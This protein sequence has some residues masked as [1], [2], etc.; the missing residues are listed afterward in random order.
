MVLFGLFVNQNTTF[1]KQKDPLDLIKKVSYMHAQ[2]CGNHNN[3]YNSTI[4]KVTFK[5]GK[6][7]NNSICDEIN[8]TF[9]C[10]DPGDKCTTTSHA[11]SGSI[12]VTS[13]SCPSGTSSK[14]WDCYK[15]YIPVDGSYQDAEGIIKRLKEFDLTLISVDTSGRE[16]SSVTGLGRQKRTVF[17]GQTASITRGYTNTGYTFVGFS[18]GTPGNTISRT[19]YDDTVIYAYY[20]GESGSSSTDINVKNDTVPKYGNYAK[21]TYAKPG[22]IRKSDWT[23]DKVTYSASYSPG[24]QSGT[25][26]YP[27]NVEIN[28]GWACGGNNTVLSMNALFNACRGSS[29]N[30]WNNAFSVTKNN[31]FKSDTVPSSPIDY[32]GFGIGDTTTISGKEN[33]HIVIP[34]EAGRDLTENAVTNRVW[35]TRDTPRSYT[36]GLAP[37]GVSSGKVSTAPLDSNASTLVPYNFINDPKKP[38]KKNPGDIPNDNPNDDDGKDDDINEDDK[39]KIV[40][41]G[42]KDTFSFNIAVNPR[43]NQETDGEYATIVEKAK[44]RLG[45]CIGD[46]CKSSNPEY[47]YSEIKEGDLNEKHKLEG[48]PSISKELDINIP[49]IKAG[50]KICVVSEVFP[51][52]SGSYLNW[53]DTNYDGTWARSPRSCYTVAKRPSIQTW[54]GNV[55]T[56][57]KIETSTAE[58]IKKNLMGYASTHDAVAEPNQGIVAFGSWNELGVVANNGIIGFGSGASM[59]YAGN[60]GIQNGVFSPW[61]MYK[62]ESNGKTASY[63][64]KGNLPI[65]NG[66]APGGSEEKSYCNRVPLTIPNA[67]CKEG[68][69]GVSGSSMQSLSKASDDKQ[70]IVDILGGNATTVD[71]GTTINQERI[72]LVNGSETKLFQSEGDIIIDSDLIYFDSGSE[73]KS[74]KDMPKLVIYA[75]NIKINCNV[76]R[77]D[78]LLI[79]KRAVLT[80][81]NLGNDVDL[82]NTEKVNEAIE[83]TKNNEENSTQL[84]VNG[85][86]IANRLI[87]NRTYGAATGPNSIISAEIINFDPTLYKFNVSTSDDKDVAGRLDVASMHELP[88]RL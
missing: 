20:R 38:T 54:G 87:A 36:I 28:G 58:K 43:Y 48:E 4:F 1:A 81:N 47:K 77:I 19:M 53:N 72:G 8:G 68:G 22:D 52:T 70:S 83:R 39:G 26:F 51:K 61:P 73:Y 50:S 64:G 17:Y 32:T 85:A 29:Y 56:Q 30:N 42:E 14:K 79:A 10:V 21:T 55:Y 76:E 2:G 18:D 71:N 60:D 33:S 69:I 46:Q 15:V 40:Y 63:R 12:K 49:D 6:G 44:W 59:G 82:S 16:L 80:C 45:L 65:I 35:G 75:D 25:R 27:Q 11:H 66:R 84:F 57:G 86:I 37:S 9:H 31:N 5:W 7:C 41:A 34:Q 67:G 13:R 78:A 88:P 23:G 24:A 3:E 62:Y 74:Y